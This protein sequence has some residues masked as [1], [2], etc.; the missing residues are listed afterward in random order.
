MC[1]LFCWPGVLQ[2]MVTLVQNLCMAMS[3]L[4]G[5]AMPSNLVSHCLLQ[6]WAAGD[7]QVAASPPR[8]GL[9]TFPGESGVA[10]VDLQMPGP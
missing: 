1:S 8:G 7:G 3:T 4:G 6:V 2:G 10:W 9:V 5:R